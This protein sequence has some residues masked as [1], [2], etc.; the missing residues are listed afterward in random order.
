MARKLDSANKTFRSFKPNV[1]G[2]KALKKFLEENQTRYAWV[3]RIAVGAGKTEYRPTA[4]DDED[5]ERLKG[6]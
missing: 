3:E 2:G 4:T 5:I 6:I 1:S